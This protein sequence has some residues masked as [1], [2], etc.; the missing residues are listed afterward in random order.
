MFLKKNPLQFLIL[1]SKHRYKSETDSDYY[2]FITDS[3]KY[4]NYKYLSI[5]FGKKNKIINLKKI[6]NFLKKKNII[7]LAEAN[8]EYNYLFYILIIYNLMHF[9][10]FQQHFPYSK[11]LF[12]FLYEILLDINY[13]N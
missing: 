4:C 9:S 2:Y 5:E 8:I 11:Y 13:Y 1:I 12:P 7:I 10:H 3:L 6:I